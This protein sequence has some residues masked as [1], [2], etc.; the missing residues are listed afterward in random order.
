MRGW[1][2]GFRVYKG[3]GLRV[4]LRKYLDDK[5]PT[6]FGVPYYDFKLSKSKKSRVFG[7]KVGFGV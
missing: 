1:G 4:W 7:V 5:E 6:L 2:L 3:L